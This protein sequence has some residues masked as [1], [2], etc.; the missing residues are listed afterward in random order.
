ML[1]GY[2]VFS[3]KFRPYVQSNLR[4]RGVVTQCVCTTFFLGFHF[5]EY[6]ILSKN[7]MVVSRKCLADFPIRS[8]YLIY[9]IHCVHGS[10]GRCFGICY[11]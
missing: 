2:Y 6:D 10:S 11:T 1:V 8:V 5:S 9:S 3:V 7:V 4:A